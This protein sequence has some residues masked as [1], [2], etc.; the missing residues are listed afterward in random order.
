MDEGVR[1][2]RVEFDSGGVRCAGYLYLPP[3]SGGDGLPCV[4]MAHGF[5]GTMEF[6]FQRAN[7][8]AEAGMAA[9]VFDY[10]H[11]GASDGHPRQL[12]DLPSQQDDWRAA[13]RFARGRPELD[14]TRVALWGSSLSGGHVITIGA[15]DQAVAA[16][17]AQVPWLGDGRPLG[18]KLRHALRW[19]SVKLTIAAV[20]D[21]RGARRGAAPLLAPVIGEPGSGAM[22]TDPAAKLALDTAGLTD[23]LWRNE[24]TP[25]VALVLARYRPGTHMA[26]LTMPVLVCASEGDVDIPLGFVRAAVARAPRG[27]LRIYPGN[28]FEIYHGPAQRQIMADQ[29]DFLRTH[30]RRP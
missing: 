22:F 25:R 2:T 30:L 3:A 20:R 16:V 6:L 26:R 4:V 28:H 14:A 23:V 8:F 24:F 17:V 1:R 15:E 29:T 5:A 11:F 10:R 27:E 13:V 9:L 12:M 18:R 21:A 19:N 7:H